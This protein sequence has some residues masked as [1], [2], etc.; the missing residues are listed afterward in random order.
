M[1]QNISA[2]GASVSYGDAS[3]VYAGPLGVSASGHSHSSGTAT[4]DIEF[5]QGSYDDF[6]LWDSG[7]P[8][9]LISRYVEGE[10][11][12]TSGTW[13]R[14]YLSASAPKDFIT[15]NGK[16]N[17]VY[18]RA[19][20]GVV[21]M[22]LSNLPNNDFEYM[23]A[24]QFE[25]IDPLTPTALAADMT[26]TDT[27]FTVSSYPPD[28]PITDY[29]FTAAQPPF[30]LV[31]G[32]GTSNQ[33]I[34]KVTSMN[35]DT[36]YV[37]RAQ[38]GTTAVVHTAGTQVDKSAAPTNYEEPRTIEI[39]M[40]ADRVNYAINP[41]FAASPG[42][43]NWAGISSNISADTSHYWIG[44]QSL[45]AV[46]QTNNA[47]CWIWNGVQLKP[48]EA[49]TW[50]AYVFA[51]QPVWLDLSN[52]YLQENEA[53]YRRVGF[54]GTGLVQLEPNSWT[55]ISGTG[56]LPIDWN[57]YPNRSRLVL[58]P[59][60]LEGT[61]A[62]QHN[63]DVSNSVWYDGVLIEEGYV[64]QDY[65]DGSFPGTDYLWETDWNGVPFTAHETTSH[66]YRRYE[67]KRYRVDALIK[68][69]L[70]LGANYRI[71]Y[72][73]NPVINISNPLN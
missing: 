42:T 52:C 29:P 45:K 34:V 56:V 5:P 21:G 18:N 39:R 27:S 2:S 19:A 69:N 63:Y 14:A 73:Q 61:S 20:Y 50:S 25:K 54:A 15:K 36:I 11:I 72:A 53:P 68:E 26:A 65:F 37:N 49:Y 48:G 17:Q 40:R 59:A 43:Y 9:V 10:A 62:G 1:T 22:R 31:L 23:D 44:T 12:T 6:G 16:G 51:T 3:P 35:T 13:T 32:R 24:V 67:T 71:Y 57:P 30:Y 8:D 70:P 47:D 55:R 64:L 38:F 60:S 58:R 33:E 41:Q 4:P 46:A 28:W 7:Q 66:Y